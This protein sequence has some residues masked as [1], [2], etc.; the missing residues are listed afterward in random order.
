MYSMFNLYNKAFKI[1]DKAE[2]LIFNTSILYVNTY[3][4]FFTGIIIKAREYAEMK[5]ES[6]KGKFYSRKYDGGLNLFLHQC[7]TSDSW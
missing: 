7:L 2:Q 5:S 3:I 1:Q 4:F 6:M